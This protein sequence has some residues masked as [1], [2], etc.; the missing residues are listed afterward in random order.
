MSMAQLIP[1]I[2]LISSFD[3][4]TKVFLAF[5]KR[6]GNAAEDGVYFNE[7]DKGGNQIPDPFA[8]AT[9]V[10]KSQVYNDNILEMLKLY[11][12][13]QGT[14]ATITI[15]A[16]TGSGNIR[17]MYTGRIE[18]RQYTECDNPSTIN[19]QVNQIEANYI[20]ENQKFKIYSLRGGLGGGWEA[21]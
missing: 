10:I 6:T 4:D 16:Y 3:S 1:G 11:S 18:N 7:I 20:N 21:H 15:V 2:N 9:R 13:K 17:T 12:N 19:G 5:E 8:T 14:Q